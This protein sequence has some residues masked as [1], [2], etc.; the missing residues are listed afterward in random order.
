[1]YQVA[2]EKGDGKYQR[3][4]TSHNNIRS[5]LQAQS[6]HNKKC[7]VKVKGKAFPFHAMRAYRGNRGIASFILNLA[8]DKN[9]WSYTLLQSSNHHDGY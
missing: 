5:N 3:H 4:I 8:P 1:M 6:V 9:E 7:K 2:Y